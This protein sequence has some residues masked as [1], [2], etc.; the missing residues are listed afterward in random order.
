MSKDQAVNEISIFIETLK[1]NTE[2]FNLCKENL[3][4]DEQK[5]VLYLVSVEL[6]KFCETCIESFKP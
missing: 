4:T 6:K 1:A 3:N 5:E 2:L